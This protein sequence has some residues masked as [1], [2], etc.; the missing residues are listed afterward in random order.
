MVKSHVPKLLAKLGLKD[1]VPTTNSDDPIPSTSNQTPNVEL[2]RDRTIQLPTHPEF[3]LFNLRKNFPNSPVFRGYTPERLGGS[4]PE[5]MRM[6][7]REPAE[8]SMENSLTTNANEESTENL[9]DA[10]EEETRSQFLQEAP[11]DTAPQIDA[12]L[13]ESQILEQNTIDLDFNYDSF[14]FLNN[15]SATR[16]DDIALLDQLLE[17]MKYNINAINDEFQ[18]NMCDV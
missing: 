2:L 13:S 12:V 15:A 11:I 10:L 7:F 14:E 3:T 8:E 9:N 4:P 18:Q 1:I 17:Y 5:F 6:S 16:E